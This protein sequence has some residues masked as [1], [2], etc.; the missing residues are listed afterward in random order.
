MD[1]AS[2]VQQVC[3]NNSVHNDKVQ[4]AMRCEGDVSLL[5]LLSLISDGIAT[6]CYSSIQKV[7]CKSSRWRR[8]CIAGRRHP[9]LGPGLQNFCLSDVEA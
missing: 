2:V 9:G 7:P 1:R 5:R 3:E 6:T 4:V 8:E